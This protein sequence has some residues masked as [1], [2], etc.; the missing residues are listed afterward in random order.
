[1]NFD[2]LK[3]DWN[4]DQPKDQDIS[5]KIPAQENSKHP[6]ERLQKSMRNEFWAQIIAIILLAGLPQMTDISS[7]YYITYYVA[8]SVLV[9]VSGY[10]LYGFYQFYKQINLFHSDTKG[11]LLRIYYELR[12]AM[13]RYQSFGFLLL[14]FLLVWFGIYSTDLLQKKGKTIAEQ[15]AN[16]GQYAVVIAVLIVTFGTIAAIVLWTKY[17]YGKYAKELEKM[18]D[19]L[20]T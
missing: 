4:A 10:Y 18:I 15:L 19:D 7:S 9:V 2:E 3:K 6:L 5:T 16:G 20:D 14:P 12:L 1:M 13:E 8:Y 17:I 11:S